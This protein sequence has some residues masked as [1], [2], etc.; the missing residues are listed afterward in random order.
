MTEVKTTEKTRP[1]RCPTRLRGAATMR[2]THFP[3]HRRA[4]DVR[5]VEGDGEYVITASFCC[6]PARERALRA[7]RSETDSN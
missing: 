4:P 6:E 7:I 5:V 2:R 3:E 1:G